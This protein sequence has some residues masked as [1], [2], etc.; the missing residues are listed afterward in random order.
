MEG[1]YSWKQ[2]RIECN[3]PDLDS[4]GKPLPPPPAGLYW[5]RNADRSWELRSID[6]LRASTS[7]SDKLTP[8]QQPCVFL[9]TV[10]PEDTLVGLA[11][12][13]HLSKQA[14]RAAN[15]FSGDNIQCKRC[16]RIPLEAGVRVQLQEDSPEVVLQ[17][18]KNHTGESTV[19]ARCYLDEAGWDLRVAI[20]SWE[21]DENWEK[22]R[23]IRAVETVVAPVNPA[24]AAPAA[25]V[26]TVVNAAALTETTTASHA[27]VSLQHA[28]ALTSDSRYITGGNQRNG[29]GSTRSASRL[30]AGDVLLTASG[31][32]RV[33]APAEVRDHVEVVPYLVAEVQ[34]QQ[35]SQPRPL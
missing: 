27:A 8:V 6:A 26:A 22:D 31:S 3:S 10:M 9:H 32:Q 7:D 35:P 1:I 12:R 25:A 33:V 18:F 17:R 19:E 20:A 2:Q 13:Y 30:F 24:H 16:L 11:L 34:P 23:F 5:Q 14:I 28:V 21:R 15:F 29:S 4:F